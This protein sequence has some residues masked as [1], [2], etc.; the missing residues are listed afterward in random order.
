MVCGKE[1]VIVIPA[2][3]QDNVF[4]SCQNNEINKYE[5]K[6]VDEYKNVHEGTY[7]DVQNYPQKF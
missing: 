6:N 1:G 2:Y 5:N 4:L 3:L 7:Q